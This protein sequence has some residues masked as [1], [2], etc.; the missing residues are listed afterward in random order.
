MFNSDHDNIFE[1]NFLDE[2][3]ILNEESNIVNERRYDFIDQNIT[4]PNHLEPGTGNPEDEVFKKMKFTYDDEDKEDKPEHKQSIFDNLG[5]GD[6][7]N[8]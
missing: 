5:F 6:R 8:P 2:D 1:T 7:V 3:P 4:F